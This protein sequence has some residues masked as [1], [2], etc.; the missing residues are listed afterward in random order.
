VVLAI[1]SMA[2]SRVRDLLE[3]EV[4][5]VVPTTRHQYLISTTGS[6]SSLHEERNEDRNEDRSED[7]NEDQNPRIW[8]SRLSADET[9]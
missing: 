3:V 5:A 8:C 6:T 7:Q 9:P 2:I 1:L 4:E